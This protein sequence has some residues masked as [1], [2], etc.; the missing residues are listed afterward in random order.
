MLEVAESKEMP[1]CWT[2]ARARLGI[3]LSH[4]E[5]GTV[6]DKKEFPEVL[7]GIE[8]NHTRCLYSTVTFSSCAS[9][10]GAWCLNPAE[11]EVF[12]TSK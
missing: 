5:F 7:E 9:L 1:H 10:A 2:H 11:S 12:K 3:S 6:K 4:S 8:G